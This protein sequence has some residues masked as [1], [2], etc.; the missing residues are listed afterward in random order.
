MCQYKFLRKLGSCL[1]SASLLLSCLPSWAAESDGTVQQDN[2]F[3]PAVQEYDTGEEVYHSDDRVNIIVELEEK[4]LLAYESRMKTF[5]SVS[6]YLDSAGAKSA[7]QQ[8]ARARTNVQR[9]LNTSGMDV[10]VE[11]EYSAVFSGLSLEAD[12][13]DLEEIRSLSGVKNA[14]VAQRHELIEPVAYEPLLTGSVPSIG[15]D[16][17]GNTGYTG[18][19]T[20]VAILDTG[21]DLSHEAFQGSVNGA[22]YDKADISDILNTKKLTVGKLS[23]ESLYQSDKVPYAYDYADCDTNVSGGES[24][25]THVAG[26]V[27]ANSGNT[28][29]GVAPDSQ[30]FIMKVFGDSTGGAYDNDI[31]AA[32]DDS[33]KLG[34]DTINMSLGSPAGFSEDSTKVMRE[35]YQRVADAGVN[36]MCAAGNSYSSS[37]MNTAGNDLPLAT[38][39]DSGTVSSPSTYAAALS[40]ASVNNMRATSPY[41]IAGSRH[42]RYNDSA[43]DISKQFSTLEGSFSY[44]DCGYGATTDFPESLSGKIALISRGGEENG[45]ILT[46]SQKQQNAKAKGAKAMIVYD[47]VEGD[48]VSMATDDLIPSVFISKA[49]GE[50]MVNESEKSIQVSGEFIE[51]YTDSYSG[52]MS[53]FSSWGVTSDLKLKP[54]ITAPG[55]N[56]YSTLPGGRYGN[57]SGTSM[58]SPHMAG[59]AAIMDQYI[60]ENLDGLSMSQGERAELANDLMMSTAVQVKDENGNASSPRQQGAGLVQLNRAV[61][62]DAYLTDEENGRPKAELGDNKDGSFSFAFKAHNLSDKTIRYE[63]S[64]TVQTEDTVAED[65]QTFI[66]QRARVLGNDEV[67]V[68]APGEVTLNGDGTAD[69]NISLALTETG[70]NNLKKVFS[71]GTFIEGYV[72]LT[73]VDENGTVSLSIPF[74]GFYGDWSSVPMFDAS[75]YDDETPAVYAMQLGQFRNSD[76]GGYILGQN[77]YCS[78]ASYDK[79]HI[80]IKGGDK[81]K[82][83]TA[84]T[85]L[86]RNADKLNFSVTDSEGELLYSETLLQQGKTY[87]D[88]QAYHTPMADKG[89]FPVD[90]WGD[91]LP[92]GSYTYTVTG[93]VGGKDQSVSFPLEIDSQKPQV[94]KSEIA[95]ENGK[96]VWKVTVSD[97]HYISAVCAT[98]GSTPLT[99]WIEPKQETAGAQAVV[100]FDLTDS[101]LKNLSSARIALADYADN[102]YISESYDLTGD[103]AEV[104][105]QTIQLDKMQLQMTQ[106]DQTTIS[107]S[108]GPENAS[109]KTVSWTTSNADVVTVDSSGLVKAVGTGNAVV[110]AK[111]VNNLTASCS[112][113]VQERQE[114]TESILASVCAPSVVQPGQ[115]I[116]FDF[117]LEKMKRVATVAFTF[118]KDSALKAE[119][120]SGLNGFTALDGIQWKTDNTGILMLSYLD[121]GAGGSATVQALTDIARVVF[122][123][124]LEDGSAGIR[125]TGVTVSGYDAS[126]KAV[127]LASSIKTASASVVVRQGINYDVN[128][129]GR[130]DQLDITYCQLYYRAE[131]G[132]SNWSTAQK[133]DLNGDHKVDVQDMVMILHYIYSI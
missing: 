89:F 20:A 48:L 38:N 90:E 112:I 34:A 25:G 97:N 106:G 85:S 3:V 57:M 47:N 59:A 83:V 131:S 100:T 33:V 88:D 101:A 108:V 111:T 133:C 30:F 95:V 122:S 82:H 49:D 118:E 69:V 71:N 44:V 103:A 4:P 94:V 93:T 124:A 18:K 19:G 104:L 127:Y 40:V 98:Q 31:L 64:V 125:M 53:D 96:R 86:L 105:P 116:P 32:L 28:V 73:P 26:I 7:E 50:A 129:D 121:K 109:D 74:M 5:S 14:F 35:V 81:T 65:G 13:G 70:K 92:D 41:F 128:G 43:D 45:E 114:E 21:L 119:S 16:I 8:L 77:L 1:L 27:G 91:A 80:A 110:T 56:I 130:V 23:V 55:G 113:T 37:Y 61:T 76:G 22:K 36:L 117:Q 46:F 62:A 12:F 42:I 54:E 72:T 39:P 9:A 78:D 6:E 68:S 10:T 99:G 17:A 11:R 79:N 115:N 102:Q 15:A 63:T 75:V 51:S 24:H 84:V 87:Y 107:A 123:T 29:K 58:A 52:K 60:R 2:L 67:T 126:G 120:V 132:D 66:A